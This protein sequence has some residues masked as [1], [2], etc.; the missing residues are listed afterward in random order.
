MAA[1]VQ[2]HSQQP[3]WQCGV[4]QL[5]RDTEQPLRRAHGCKFVS[6]TKSFARPQWS[7][8]WFFGLIFVSKHQIITWPSVISPVS[9]QDKP[10]SLNLQHGAPLRCIKHSTSLLHF[11]LPATRFHL[12]L[13]FLSPAPYVKW[14]DG[15]GKKNVLCAGHLWPRDTV[16]Q[17]ITH[18]SD[19]LLSVSKTK[20]VVRET[21]ILLCCQLCYLKYSAMTT[22]AAETSPFT[23]AWLHSVCQSTQWR[24]ALQKEK[25]SSCRKK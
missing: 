6:N 4:V 8:S 20:T 10:V 11:V 17:V 3:T 16:R 13:S 15:G 22:G 5:Q 18:H 7:N 24:W 21:L 9:A 19:F 12:S 2:A 25:K 1:T 14:R 23:S